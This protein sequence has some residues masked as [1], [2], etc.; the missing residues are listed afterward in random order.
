MT[1]PSADD[2]GR[3]GRASRRTFLGLGA[4]VVAAGISAAAVA[5]GT[6][7]HTAS[8]TRPAPGPATRRCTPGPG[9]ELAARGPALGDPAPRRAGRDRGVR[10][11]IQRADRGVLPSVRLDDRGGV[12]DHRVP[13]R[14][15]RRGRRPPGLA[16]GPAARSPAAP[17]Q[18]GRCHQHGAGRLG[19]VRRS[20]DRRLAAGGI[21][22]PA[23]R[24]FRRAAVRAGDGPLVPYRWPGRDQELRRHLAG[25]QHLGRLRPVRGTGIQLRG[26]IAGGQPGPAIRRRTARPCS[27]LTSG[28]W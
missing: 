28:T 10:G 24:G 15:V 1:A 16:V 20:A 5:V 26:A 7:N 18:P 25:L 13:A 6:D 22:A 9:G 12:P 4:A 11:R 21:P 19:S 14:L 23:G 2:A 27:S 17:R 8:S 3:A